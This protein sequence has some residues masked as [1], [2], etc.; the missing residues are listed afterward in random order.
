MKVFTSRSNYSIVSQDIQRGEEEE[1]H[2]ICIRNRDGE[3]R[4]YRIYNLQISSSIFPFLSL[5]AFSISLCFITL[6]YFLSSPSEFLLINY[7]SIKYV[8]SCS[9][10]RKTRGWKWR[11]VNQSW[12]RGWNLPERLSS[13]M[14]SS[15]TSFPLQNSNAFWILLPSHSLLLS[16]T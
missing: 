6:G 4:R 1:K 9:W 5:K 8:S 10:G 12:L 7:S 14:S 11:S 13:S 15:S 3:G 16:S 2:Q